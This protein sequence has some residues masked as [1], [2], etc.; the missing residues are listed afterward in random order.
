VLVA[1]L[2]VITPTPVARVPR[3][4]FRDSIAILREKPRLAGYLAIVMA[5]GI[6][7]DPI[8]TE[9]PAI[10]HVFGYP[11]VWAGAVVGC[12]G[13]G[14]VLAAILTSDRIGGSDRHLARS[15]LLFG[16]GMVLMAVSPWLPL[17]LAFVIGAGFGYLS[18]NA[19]ATA[20]LQLGVAEEQ[21][22]RIMALWS[23]AFLG[24]RPFASLVDGVL[25]ERFGVRLAAAVL[26][27]PVLVAAVV[28]L[29]SPAKSAERDPQPVR[30]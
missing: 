8:N 1:A 16:S 5:V 28:L 11:P 29:R 6:T 15:L 24:A 21:R 3:S 18:A 25:A 20:R 26:A 22:G 30:G 4:S 23:V 17:A 9:S 14:A 19:T 12:F 2:L 10:A 13:L 7:S 27:T